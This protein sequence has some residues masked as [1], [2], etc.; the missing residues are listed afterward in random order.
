MI[1]RVLAILFLL[2]STIGFTAVVARAQAASDADVNAYVELLRSDLRTRKAILIGEQLTL[3]NSESNSFWPIYKRYEMAL[4]ALNNA[5]IALM[6]D[7]A[8]HYGAMTGAK[9]R[10]LTIRSLD[11]DEKRQML[12]KKFYQEFDQV[13]NAK[14]AAQFVQFDRRI[15]LLIDLQIAAELLMIK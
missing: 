7:Y 11:L 13:L 3:T 4:M 8:E 6:K 5:K 15:D 14:S 12:R 2:T 9:A 10:D 1:K